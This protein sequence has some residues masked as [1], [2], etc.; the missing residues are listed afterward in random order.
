M[1]IVRILAV[2][3]VF[4]GAPSAVAPAA[5]R[6]SHMSV[7]A[8]ANQCFALRAAGDSRP[9]FVAARGGSY[10]ASAPSRARATAFYLKPTGLGT[11]MLYDSDARLMRAGPGG[12]V[13]RASAAG[14]TT[15]FALT[16]VGSGSEF[17]LRSTADH[18][19]AVV[20]RAGRAALALT[21]G[22]GTTWTFVARGG[23]TPFPEAGVDGTVHGAGTR[24]KHGRIFGFIDDH[25]HITGNTRAGGDVISG[26]PYDRFGIPTALGED[27]KVHGAGGKLDLTG[28]LLRSGV[29]VGSH[30]TTAGRALRGGRRTTR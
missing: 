7:Y 12:S 3:A 26:E 11:Y 24:V 27:A 15:E 19:R 8:P 17:T 1:R 9:A 2:A 18:R 5:G 13:T 4:A 30:D 14:P 20:S 6:A 28:N 25:L 22:A 16:A 29:P 10:G 23:C 21:G